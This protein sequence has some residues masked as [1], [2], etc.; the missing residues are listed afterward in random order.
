[1][2]LVYSLW[3]KLRHETY[4]MPCTLSPDMGGIGIGVMRNFLGMGIP[5]LTHNVGEQPMLYHQAH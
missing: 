4:T 5:Q 3:N 2:S 1:M